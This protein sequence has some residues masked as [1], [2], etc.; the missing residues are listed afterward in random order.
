MVYYTDSFRGCL[1]LELAVGYQPKLRD[2]HDVSVIQQH[3]GGQ[4]FLGVGIYRSQNLSM[5][6]SEKRVAPE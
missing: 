3:G 2:C 6:A 5:V 1:D 4:V